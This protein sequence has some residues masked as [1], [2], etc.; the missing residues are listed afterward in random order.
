MWD[1]QLALKILSI[2]GDATGDV[3]EENQSCYLLSDDNDDTIFDDELLDEENEILQ[4]EELFDMIVDNLSLSQLQSSL[5]DEAHASDGSFEVDLSHQLWWKL[6]RQLILVT[7]DPL[8]YL[9][10]YPQEKIGNHSR[11][12]TESPTCFQIE[13]PYMVRY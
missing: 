4:D 11:L 9:I 10:H 1:K 8:L 2:M 5:F 3:N 13:E 7:S 12:V 6:L